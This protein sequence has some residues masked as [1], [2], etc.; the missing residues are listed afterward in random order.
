MTHV[1]DA[2]AHLMVQ[3]R[4]GS[5]IP[6]FLLGTF[7]A[8]PIALPSLPVSTNTVALAL[9]LV[10]ASLRRPEPGDRLPA[11]APMIVVAMIAWIGF[12]LFYNNLDTYAQ[13]AYFAT[14]AMSILAFASG[15]IDR[16]SICR[17]IGLGLLVGSLGGLASFFFGIGSNSY[18]G[19]L[20]GEFWGDPNQAGYFLAVLTPLA[21]VGLRPGWRRWPPLALFTACLLLTY[22]R[23]SWMAL[24]LAGLWFLLRRRL[25][26]TLGVTVLAGAA[27]L[28][29]DLLD[30]LRYWGPFASRQGSDDL[31]ERIAE[32]SQAAVNINPFVGRGPGTASVSLDDRTFYF[33]NAYLAVRNN[34]GW[35]L[36][37]LL[38]LLMFLVTLD[39]LRRPAQEH[40]P[41]H[42]AALIALLVCAMS[43]GEAFLRGP[44][45]LAIGLALRHAINPFELRR[46]DQTDSPDHVF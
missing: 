31:R 38:L 43:L 13:W 45:A 5:R 4:D 19:R 12:S 25:S 24:A 36:L 41:W 26:P 7:L 20:T 39:M 34:G 17:G 42:E 14:W 22:S 10:L 9:V 1:A 2:Y 15:R 18:P 6:D 21:L 44:S 40:H 35:V 11:W 8:L 16:I 23:T 33:H 27:Y 28:L 29:N 46:S 32:L 3:R 37:A 30:R